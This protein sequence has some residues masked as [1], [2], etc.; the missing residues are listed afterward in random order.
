[1]EFGCRSEHRVYNNL[2]PRAPAIETPRY[3]SFHI[4]FRQGCALEIGMRNK[5]KKTL[6]VAINYML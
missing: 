4:G 2:K 5:N 1:M 6:P 3:P